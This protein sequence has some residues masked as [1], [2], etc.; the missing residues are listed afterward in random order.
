MTDFR[1]T[2]SVRSVPDI[3]RRTM[4]TGSAVAVLAAL[5]ACTRD[6]PARGVRMACGEPGGVYIEFGELLARSVFDEK[7]I[8]VDA[9]TTNGSAE[10]LALL[11]AGEVDLGIALADS[12]EYRAGDLTALGSVYQNYLQ[13]VVRE[14]G[15][16]S[17]LEDL[18]GRRVSIG[19][20]GSGSSFTTNR[21]MAATGL[22]NGLAPVD[23]VEQGLEEALQSLEQGEIDAMF[24]SGGIPTPRISELGHSTP[25]RLLDLAPAL[26]ALDAEYPGRYLPT[27]VPA[28]VYAAAEPVSTIGISNFLL[29]RRDLPDD[30]AG[31]LVTVL[32]NRAH[33]LIPPGTVGLQFLTAASLIDTGDIPLHPAAQQ[34]YRELYG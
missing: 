33:S 9:R 22:A 30:I 3:T 10:N 31:A 18:A 20:P 13:C 15:A 26:T 17:R 12:A 7:N 5:A 11:T 19:A 25:V 6:A 2:P 23:V 16:I 27:R 4:L 29:A 28:G 34:R 1:R 14:S 8:R 24:W 21:L 32:I